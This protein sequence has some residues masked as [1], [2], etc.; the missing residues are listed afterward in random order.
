MSSKGGLVFTFS[1][2]GV[3]APPRPVARI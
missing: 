3:A 1:L 2:P